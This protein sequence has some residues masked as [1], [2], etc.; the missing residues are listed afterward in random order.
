[1]ASVIATYSASLE[2]KATIHCFLLDHEIRGPFVLSVKQYPE[3][4]RQS[5]DEPQSKLVKPI[6]S[7]SF[8]LGKV[9][10]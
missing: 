7:T 1:M 6:I 3:I 8:T 9:K 10:P 2:D 4:L 5:G